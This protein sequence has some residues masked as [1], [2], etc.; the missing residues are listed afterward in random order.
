MEKLKLALSKL[1]KSKTVVFGFV[2]ML[3]G[4]IQ[5]YLPSI[6]AAL[7]PVTYGLI[8]ASVGIAVVVLRYFTDTSLQDK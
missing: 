6:Q 1:H 5:T 4:A 8:T 2:V 7:D 3:L